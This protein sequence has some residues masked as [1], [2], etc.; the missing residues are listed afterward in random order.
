MELL[1]EQWLPI[2]VTVDILYLVMLSV[3]VRVMATGMAKYHSAQRVSILLLTDKSITMCRCI[4][5]R[6]YM[7][8]Y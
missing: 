3:S 4:R 2:N 8:Q 7:S 5:V 1:K 6:T